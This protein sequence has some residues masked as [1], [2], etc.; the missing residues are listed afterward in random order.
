VEIFVAIVVGI[1]TGIVAS[2][3]FA[4]SQAWKER[5]RLRIRYSPTS[6]SF[7]RWYK[8]DKIK[9][10]NR[11]LAR[12][13]IHYTDMSNLEI[14][15]QT[16]INTDDGK[17]YQTESIEEWTGEITMESPRNGYVVWEQ[18]K[19]DNG[20]NGFKRIIV[21]KDLDGITLVGETD[22]GFGTERFTERAE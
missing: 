13:N 20:N 10:N 21:D 7:I 12:A 11:V 3:L 6:G 19:P 4:R 17:D 9:G 8:D 5:R 16:L 14:K 15:V 22:R 2:L 18:R 1:G